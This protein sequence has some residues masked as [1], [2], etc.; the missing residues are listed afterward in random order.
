M[1]ILP[2][3][4]MYWMHFL[5][6]FQCYCSQ[7]Y[8]KN[9]NTHMEAQMTFVANAKDSQSNPKKTEQYCKY[10]NARV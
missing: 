10:N 9:S 3:Y 7:T 5:L 1:A 4:S 8:K 6:K 2:K